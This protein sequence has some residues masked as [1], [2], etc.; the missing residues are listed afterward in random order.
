[1]LERQNQ[2]LNDQ[3]KIIEEENLILKRNESKNKENDDIVNKYE[4]LK[5][6]FALVIKDKEQLEKNKLQE[7]AKFNQAQIICHNC[8]IWK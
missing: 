8:E 7:T 1:M 4:S 3:I 6:K 2:M 5:I